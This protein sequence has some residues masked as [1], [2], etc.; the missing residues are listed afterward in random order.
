MHFIDCVPLHYLSI[1]LLIMVSS[2]FYIA[3]I[4]QHFVPFPALT[5]SVGCIYNLK[6]SPTTTCIILVHLEKSKQNKNGGQNWSKYNIVMRRQAVLTNREEDYE[7]T[8]ERQPTV[9]RFTF[10]P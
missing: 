3:F 8:K 9:D 10:S 6:L 1:Y 5:L 2:S 7:Q 4:F